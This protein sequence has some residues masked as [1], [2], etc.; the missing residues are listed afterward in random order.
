MKKLASIL[1][2]LVLLVA[3]STLSVMAT[4]TAADTAADT[5]A[6]TAADTAETE[7]TETTDICACEHTPTTQYCPTCGGLNPN[8]DRRWTCVCGRDVYTA[9]C[10][11]CGAAHTDHTACWTCDQCEQTDNFGDTCSRCEAARPTD[12]EKTNFHIDMNSLKTTLPIMGMGMLGIF[13]VILVIL[14]SVMILRKLPEK[15]EE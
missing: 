9:Y 12:G 1:A 14:L 2:V 7:P 3:F 5:V 10:P 6:D 11:A 4:D 8:A 13:L 15:K